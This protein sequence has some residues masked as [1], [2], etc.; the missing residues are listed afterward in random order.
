MKKFILILKILGA[1]V[2]I[3][4]FVAAALITVIHYGL[5]RMS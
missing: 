2:F 5:E 1:L 3:G 4:M